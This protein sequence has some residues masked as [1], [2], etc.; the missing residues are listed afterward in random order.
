M[1]LTLDIEM[2]FSP[3]S[4]TSI[5]AD[6]RNEDLTASWGGKGSGPTDRI[7][8]TGTL[9]FMLE[10]STA[11]SGGL[12]GYYS[13]DNANL[14]ANFKIGTP[15]RIKV[16]GASTKYKK[17]Y[18]SSINPEPGKFRGLGC[19]ITAQ[20]YIA[21]MSSQ[22][23]NSLTVQTSKR[24]DQALT[25]LI[26]TMPVAPDGTSYSTGLETL[27]YVFHDVDGRKTTVMNVVQRLLQSDLGYVG[28]DMN[29]T[30]GE[31]LFYQT[32]QDRILDASI[33]TLDNTMD[34]LELE[35]STGNIFNVM[36]IISHPVNVGAAAEVLYTLQNETQIDPGKSMSFTARYRDVNVGSQSIR[37]LD[38]SQVTP[39]ANTD[40]K[41]TVTPGSGGNDANASLSISLSWFA[42]AA[43]VVLTNI[44]AV[45]IYTGGAEIFQLR[46]KGIR[47]YDTAESVIEDSV[48]NL[49][50]YG[51]SPLR[52]DLPYQNSPSIAA[53][54]AN[55][56]FN[57]WHLPTSIIK[58]SEFIAINSAALE[59]AMLTGVIGAKFTHTEAV[60]GINVEFCING[61]EWKIQP[62]G[63]FRCRWYLEKA[64]GN[65]FWFLGESGYSEIGET[66]I[67]GF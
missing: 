14:R 58:S 11:S 5:L 64:S 29:A 25:T 65:E 28:A 42:D 27:P 53:D 61:I 31:T 34:A 46:G 18:I 33:A 51:N 2:E 38:G 43:E 36:T 6:V 23:A 50:F 9:S 52:F 19:A 35:H 24:V 20:D 41:A 30:D 44:G 13:P 15:V 7:A 66:T 54:F 47:L 45:T 39:V 8:D 60:T 57:R 1:T 59:S 55:Y 12:I 22:Y 40:Y 62:S 21:K 4:W 10:N 37:L 56:L 49:D 17:F 26:A 63:M 3:G 16:T 67:L 48:A 32:R